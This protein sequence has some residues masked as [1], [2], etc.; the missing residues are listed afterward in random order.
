MNPKI[1]L[2]QALTG[3]DPRDLDWEK[4][5]RDVFNQYG[6]SAV[7]DSIYPLAECLCNPRKSLLILDKYDLKRKRVL[8]YGCGS[9][10]RMDVAH[11]RGAQFC[12]GY[13]VG[14][15]KLFLNHYY[16]P[17]RPPSV[18]M[19]PRLVGPRFS[20][21]M[22]YDVL[23]HVENPDWTI[24]NL[25][26]KCK[27]GGLIALNAPFHDV[28]EKYPLHL[29]K[30]RYLTVDMLMLGHPVE[31]IDAMDVETE[32]HTSECSLWRRYA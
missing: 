3:H 11:A 26:K 28:S 17:T 27:V 29:E 9:G 30:H 4:G 5:C 7:Y 15:T 12:F 22:C 16:R 14:F 31:K 6:R 19:L 23:E 25:I 32:Y 20:V 13:E 21:I 2:F 24:Q 8:D 18:N 1:Q 10:D